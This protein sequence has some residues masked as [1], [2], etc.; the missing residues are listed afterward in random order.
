MLYKALNM[1][2]LLACLCL[3]CACQQSAGAQ[4]PVTST[5]ETSGAYPEIDKLITDRMA[6]EEIPGLAVVIVQGQQVVYCKGFSVT[7]LEHPSPVTPQTIFDLASVSKSFTAMGVLLLRDKG[8]IDLDAPVQ[9]YLPDFQLEDPRGAD[10]TVRQ[11]LNQTSGLPGSL[12]AP[13]IFQDGD[14]PFKNLVAAACEL[15]MNRDPGSSFEYAD[16]NYCLL[17]A[18]IERVSG[19]RFEDYMQQEIFAPLGMN[20]TT[21]YPG[22]AASLDRADGHQ[23]MYGRVIAHNMP[24]YRSAE[25]AG[26]VMSCAEDMGRW[27][28]LHLNGID[29]QPITAE[30]IEECHSP[31]S[32]FLENGEMV[33]YGMGWLVSTD[34]DVNL[35]W[36]G[37][38]TQNFTS[39][40][41]LLPDYQTAVVVLVNSQASTGHI[42]APEIINSLLGL[43]LKAMTVPWWAHWKMIDRIASFCLIPIFLLSA[44]LVLYIWRIWWQFHRGRRRFA[45][46]RDAGPVI[47]AWQMILYLTPFVLLGMIS[48]ATYLIFHTI[49]GYN[50]FEVLIMFNIAAPPGVYASGIAVL[51]LLPLW[52]LTLVF[53]ALLTHPAKMAA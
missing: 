52:A 14:D 19:L 39:D 41:I 6:A 37:G 11:L 13:L 29:C 10:I 53:V 38:D 18:L 36:H 26:W 48:L 12:S 9:R 27:I 44:G 21:L 50:P 40:M 16:I 23:P 20:N 49:Y 46:A 7:S 22:V 51:V 45:W 8:L 5:P 30:D 2:L 33:G 28:C 24:I 15:D 35:V 31:A 4:I 47:P 1:A 17:G 25:P 43:N 34:D 42:I 3:L 32:T